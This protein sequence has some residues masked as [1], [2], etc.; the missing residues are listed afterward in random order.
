MASQL[1]SL[2][3]EQCASR[4]IAAKAPEWK[5]VKHAAQWTSTLQ[6]YAFPVIGGLLVQDVELPQIKAVLDPIWVAKTETAS[7]LRG[8][9]ESVLDWA[10]V[11]GYRTG[12]NPARWR[13][14]LDKVLPAPGRIAKPDHHAALPLPEVGAFMKALRSQEGMGALALEFAILTAARSGEVRGAT[15]DEIDLDG[16]VWT[17]AGDRMKA[18]KEHRVPLS[19]AAL[20][21]LSKVPRMAGTD[22]VFPAPLGGQLS[23][24]TLTAVTRRMKVAAVPHGFRSTFRDWCSERTN[25]PREVVEMALAHAIGDKVEAAYRRGDLFEKRR[26]LMSEW[27]RFCAVAEP[28]RGAVVSLSKAR[29]A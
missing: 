20:A 22:L 23:D 27:A 19:A 16:A 15:W 1:A 9:I 7:R 2:T 28:S 4:Y 18:G 21:V 6:T 25:Y 14:H 17:I 10:T 3:F 12:L 24:M 5:N 13:G 26:A 11:N 8:R 29:R